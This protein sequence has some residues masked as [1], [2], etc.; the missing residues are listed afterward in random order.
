V[1]IRDCSIPDSDS[2]HVC[3]LLG[4]MS[5]VHVCLIIEMSWVLLVVTCKSVCEM[6]FDALHHW[7]VRHLHHAVLAIKV[8]MHQRLLSGDFLQ[9]IDL[10]SEVDVVLC[11]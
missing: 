11:E 2:V 9:C 7:F 6:V 5:G 3:L 4:L 8:V 1:V 10:A